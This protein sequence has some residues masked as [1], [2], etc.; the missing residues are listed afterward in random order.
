MAQISRN[1][2]A[3]RAVSRGI[4]LSQRATL[5]RRQMACH[6]LVLALAVRVP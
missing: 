5:H 6:T 4:I 1:D 2:L 3:S